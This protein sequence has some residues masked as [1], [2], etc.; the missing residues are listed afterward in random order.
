MRI[1]CEKASE[2]EIARTTHAPETEELA[3][4]VS[5]LS[6]LPHPFLTMRAFVQL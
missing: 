6:A 3:R 5:V 1:V 2:A 4:K